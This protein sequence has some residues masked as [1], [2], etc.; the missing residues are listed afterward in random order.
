MGMC[1]VDAFFTAPVS[2]PVALGSLEHSWDWMKFFKGMR[3]CD[4]GGGRRAEVSH[5]VNQGTLGF[6]LVRFTKS[7]TAIDISDQS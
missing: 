5:A 1:G 4:G 6:L 2:I 7:N 3:L